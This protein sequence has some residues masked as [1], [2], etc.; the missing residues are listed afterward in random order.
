[1]GSGV[2]PDLWSPTNPIAAFQPRL[3]DDKFD[4]YRFVMYDC[5]TTVLDLLN[6]AVQQCWGRG[7]DGTRKPST[8]RTASLKAFLPLHVRPI[9]LVVFQGSLVI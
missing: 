9:N 3:G 5:L 6:A 4:S 7:P 1:M 8:I 2:S